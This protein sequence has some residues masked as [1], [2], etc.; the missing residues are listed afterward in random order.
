LK[1]NDS[2]ELI[3]GDCLIEMQNIPTK[4]IDLVLCDLPYNTTNCKWDALIPFE[5]LWNEY[6][7]VIKDNGAILLF[8]SQPF[9]SALIM[10]QPKLFKY[11]W[12]WI[13]NRCT[14]FVQAHR[15]PMKKQ[16]NIC[17]FYKK[18]PTYNAQG[19][20]PLNKTVKPSKSQL[21]EDRFVKQENTNEYV[22]AFTNYPNDLLYFDLD[23]K[24]QHPTAKPVALLEY[25]IKTYT[26]ENET[27][28]DNTFGSCSTGVACLNTGRKFIG[29]EMND[30]FFN[31]GVDRINKRLT[32]LNNE[33]TN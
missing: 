7:R 6:K 27:V 1:V 12:I 19:L 28:L 13:K 14:K 16:E 4:S 22:Q 21:K 11:E 26:N 29:M 9:T 3:N 5:P 31:I 30:V 18:T 8:S 15:M 33:T 20:Q 10:S 23:P 32:E 17:V 25:L 2:I 24:G